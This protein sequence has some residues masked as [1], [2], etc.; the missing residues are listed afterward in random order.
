MRVCIIGRG[1]VGRTLQRELAQAGVESKLVA[2]RFRRLPGARDVYLLAVPDARLSEVAQALVP[3]VDR[4]SV[5]LH[6]AGARDQHALAALR[7]CGARVGVFHPL[8]SFATAHAAHSLRGVT[9]TSFGDRAAIAAARKL[10]RLLR[11]HLVVLE[12]APG[13]AYHAAAAL[14][15]NGAAAL[16]QLGARALG[17][18]GFR[19][20]DAERALST[21]LSS[22][23]QNIAQV[24]LP[25]AL[26]GPVARGDAATVAAHVGALARIDRE[27]VEAYL[28]LQPAVLATAKAAGLDPK[29]ARKLARTLTGLAETAR[30]SRPG[31]RSRS[32]RPRP[33]SR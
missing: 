27:L 15:A 29:L 17:Q 2:G 19:Q 11:A 12:Q 30:T 1:K 18:V 7:A 3:H 28:A 21:L 26:T 25:G 10:A 8:V 5:V 32:N 31:V 16:A 9:F 6:C 24:G 20:R 14:V 22:V 33:A 23:A 4:R 13:P